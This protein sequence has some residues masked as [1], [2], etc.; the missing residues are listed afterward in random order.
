M[1]GKDNVSASSK[2]TAYRLSAN[3]R[4]AAHLAEISNQQGDLK[5]EAAARRAKRANESQVKG[6]ASKNA[7]SRPPAAARRSNPR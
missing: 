5:R 6:K 7:V 4:R 3:E 1:A 2:P